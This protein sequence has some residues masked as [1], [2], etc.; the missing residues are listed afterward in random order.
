MFSSFFFMASM[1]NY[2]FFVLLFFFL[3][4]HMYNLVVGVAHGFFSLTCFLRDTNRR[5]KSC[6]LFFC[7]LPPVSFHGFFFKGL[8]F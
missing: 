8:F 5:E 1:G 6:Y 4:A 2:L 7:M 3:S